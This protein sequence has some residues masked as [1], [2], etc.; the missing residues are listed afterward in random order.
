MSTFIAITFDQKDNTEEDDE[1]QVANGNG[2]S[3][4]VSD[5]QPVLD[6]GWSMNKGILMF[7]MSQT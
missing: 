3:E 4:H 1:T 6:E 2:T 5:T 7:T